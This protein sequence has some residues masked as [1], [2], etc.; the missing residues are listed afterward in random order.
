MRPGTPCE[1]HG[2]AGLRTRLMCTPSSWTGLPRWG[3]TR[4]QKPQ[5]R[6]KPGGSAASTQLP[7]PPPS[8]FLCQQEPLRPRLTFCFGRRRRHPLRRPVCSLPR[9]R[10]LRPRRRHGRLIPIHCCR[11]IHRALCRRIAAL[12]A[13]AAGL[14][15]EGR[16]VGGGDGS[17]ALQPLRATEQGDGVGQVEPEVEVAEEERGAR[18]CRCRP[19]ARR[20]SAPQAEQGGGDE[21][22]RLLP[23]ARVGRG[24]CRQ[25][26]EVALV[27]K[28]VDVDQVEHRPAS[29][30][31]LPAREQVPLARP[32]RAVEVAREALVAAVAGREARLRDER[33]VGGTQALERPRGALRLLPPPEPHQLHRR[34]P[35]QID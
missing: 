19:S 24:A 16:R 29:A 33:A 11:R 22:E 23:A 7:P 15:A 14:E 32:S 12:A 4:R 2:T 34:A 26:G 31:E 13:A 28:V 10:P 18:R 35:N 27:V 1:S 25:G 5:T 9:R 8:C 21:G 20:P 30:A 3:W 17:R 6:T